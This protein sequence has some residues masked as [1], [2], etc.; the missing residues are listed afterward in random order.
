MACAAAGATLALNH[1]LWPM[2]MLVVLWLCSS[3]EYWRPGAWLFLAPACL[4]FMNFAPWTG[5]IAFDEFD[6]LL[7][8]L[9]A[10]GYARADWG[11]GKRSSKWS[12]TLRS[13]STVFVC[14]SAISGIWALQR[15]VADA[16]GFAFDWFAGYSEAMNS[17]RV[18]KSLAFAGLFY[19]LL[20]SSMAKQP[21]RAGRSLALGMVTGL[22]VLVLAVVWERAGFVGLFNFSSNYRTVGLFWEMHV[23]G[24]AIDGYLALAVPFVA[25]ALLEIK[26]PLPWL[27]AA[28]LAVLAAYA[29]LSTFSRGVYLATLGPMFLLPF[30]LHRRLRAGTRLVTGW[31]SGGL[32]GLVLILC[33]EVVAVLAMGSFMSE[34]ISQTGQDLGSR[35]EHWRNGLALLDSRASWVRGIGLGR[36]PGAY[37]ASVSGENFPAKVEVGSEELQS[38]G[39]VRFVTLQTPDNLNELPGAY[40]LTQRVRVLSEGMHTVKMR[41][42]TFVGADVALELCERHLLYDRKCQVAE[43]SIVAG[44]GGWQDVEVQLQ[45]PSIALGTLLTSRLQML[46]VSLTSANSTVSFGSV[47]FVDAHG[48]QLLEN[49]DFSRGLAHWYPAAQGY[50]V[51]WHIDN[52]YLEIL[53]EKGLLGAFIFALTLTFGLWCATFGELRKWAMSPFVLCA[54]AGGLLVGLVSS[55]MDVPRVA[56]LFNVLILV[57]VSPAP[58]G[59]RENV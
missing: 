56:F 31:R 52:L 58:Q 13:P 20:N 55:V 8:G 28:V 21:D 46:A 59:V 53:I 16:G 29:C 15:G 6:T 3:L 27:G 22:S 40:A 24:A 14:L 39:V 26:R 49:I 1:P 36:L 25:W 9:L 19:P 17:V 23:G 57:L 48:N 11:A 12:W 7:L 5:W 41:V 43:I 4:P 2:G 35:V 37:A 54:L 18:F 30:L 47:K 50:F 34:R 42:K 10:G 45:G 32:H 51:P 38:S 33:L 44:D